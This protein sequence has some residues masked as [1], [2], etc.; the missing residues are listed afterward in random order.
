MKH[1]LFFPVILLLTLLLFTAG[2]PAQN[3]LAATALYVCPMHPNEKSDKPGKC[4][5]CG[6][7]LVK[8][9]AIAVESKSTPQVG[10][11]MAPLT[12]PTH[13]GRA[14]KY[15]IRCWVMPNSECSAECRTAMNQGSGAEGGTHCV[16]V[17]VRTR[18]T[19]KSVVN[20]EVWF[21]IVYPGKRNLMPKLTKMGEVY[22]GPIDLS[23]KGRY[24]MMAHVNI[25][26]EHPKTTFAY[27][28][29]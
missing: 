23:E 27:R 12:P 10:N 18:N 24:K 19:K 7:D 8:S 25:G 5:I 22:A 2:L 6:M 13:H 4:S 20:A 16:M 28:V 14:G 26:E 15:D 3:T 21:H 17:S 11:V 29:K 9:K 1:P